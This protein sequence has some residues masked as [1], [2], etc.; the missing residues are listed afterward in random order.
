[1]TIKNRLFFNAAFFILS[2]SLF[3]VLLL[4]FSSELNKHIEQSEIAVDLVQNTIEL[5]TLTEEYTR[6]HYVRSERQWQ[7]QF[8]TL[9]DIIDN[10]KSNPSFQS[11]QEPISLLNLYFIRLTEEF[12]NKQIIIQNDSSAEEI[13]IINRME[14]MLLEQIHV[15]TQ[16]ILTKSFRVQDEAEKSIHRIQLKMTLLIISFVLIIIIFNFFNSINSIRKILKPLNHLLNGVKQVGGEDFKQQLI[17]PEKELPEDSNDEISELTTAFNEMTIRLNETFSNL[18][19]EMNERKHAEIQLAHSQKMDSLGQ[20]A[21]G[22][23]HDFN[24]VLNGIM[25][26]AELLQLSQSELD[27]K[28]LKY[29][30]IILEASK[31]ASDLIGKLLAFGRK[32]SLLFSPVDIDQ[33]L[34]DS[35]DILNGTIDKKIAITLKKTVRKKNINGDLSGLENAIINLCINSSQAM[36]GG[37]TIRITTENVYLDDS[38]CES[39][40]FDIDPGEYCK[41]TLEDTGAGIPSEYLAKIFDPFFTTK[42]LGKGTGLGLATVYGTIRNHKGEILV[43]SEV[44]AGTTFHLLLPC[45]ELSEEQEQL[46]TEGMNESDLNN[47]LALLVDDEEFNRILGTEILKSLG[48]KVLL[49]NDGQESVEIFEKYHEDIDIVI[50]DMIM[51]RMN[52]SEAFFKIKEIDENCKVIIT[53]GYTDNENI[54]KLINSGLAGFINKPYRIYELRQLLKDILN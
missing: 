10:N 13:E 41:I 34:D 40:L 1:M 5:I 26:A 19:I 54:S 14:N 12:R 47:S 6:N 35:L 8:K 51:P 45:I 22:M 18:L 25:G 17:I 4:V 50:M 48:Y 32:E 16:E 9:F 52:G 42:E 49:A 27:G 33:V 36:E 24:N 37:G 20:L 38:Y 44:G 31:R 2:G 43:S 21:G 46:E 7:Y 15:S 23:A 39:S 11:I 53:S 3:F 29:T 28:A 30:D